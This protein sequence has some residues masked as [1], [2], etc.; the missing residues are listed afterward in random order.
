MFIVMYKRISWYICTQIP[1][2]RSLEPETNKSIRFT[3][4]SSHLHPAPIG[5][6]QLSQFS[7]C[8]LW[9][10]LEVDFL[11]TTSSFDCLQYQDKFGG[12]FLTQVT[13][14]IIHSWNRCNKKEEGKKTSQ[15]FLHEKILSNLY[16]TLATNK[17]ES[18]MLFSWPKFD[19]NLILLVESS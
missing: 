11:L 19:I 3:V 4:K 12:V 14:L 8:P 7:S 2:D 13:N 17:K 10:P 1:I 6:Y 5:L 16:K 18:T 9:P 15:L